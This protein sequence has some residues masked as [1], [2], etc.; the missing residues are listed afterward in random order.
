MS[1]STNKLRSGYSHEMFK[2]TLKHCQR[3]NG[4]RLLS[5]KLELSLMLKQRKNPVSALLA[6]EEIFVQKLLLNYIN[7]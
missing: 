5:L 3:H 4:P 2:R 1:F 6:F 7:L